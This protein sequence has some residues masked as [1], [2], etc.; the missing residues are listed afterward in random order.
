MDYKKEISDYLDA[1]LERKEFS[2]DRIK[3]QIKSSGFVCVFGIGAISYPIISSIR[4]FTDIKIDF[5][6]D[7][8]RTKWGKTYHDDLKCISPKE[9]EA[10]KDDIAI[11]ITTRHYK[12]IYKQL[13]EKGFKKIYAV[14][15]YRLL[16]DPY[17][18]N[19]ENIQTIKDNVL[20]VTDILEDER[21]KEIMFTVI[22]NWF[23]FDVD[24]EGYEGIFTNDQYYPADIIKLS[25]RESFVDVGAYNGDTV[26]DFLKETNNQFDS[27]FAFELDKKNFKEME[28]V[29]DK[30]AAPV[31]KKIK[32]YNFGLLDEE[33]EVYYETGGSGMQSTFINVINTA[34]DCGKTVR[35]TDILKNEKVT[36]IKMDIEGSEVK[37]LSGAEVIIKRQKPKLAICV[38]HKP[39]HLWEVPLY[40][41][42]IVPEYKMYLRHHT[43]LEYETVCYALI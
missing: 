43:P 40:V 20:K 13:S 24:T 3:A 2:I 19:K 11:L 39:E 23:D 22:K 42:T 29:V 34:S 25:A 4:N 8:D 32:L 38:Y 16:N 6:S 5:L 10:Y 7:N 28:S 1:V 26:I 15:E 12:N 37:A 41:K 18:K 9:L 31:K 17:F 14:T 33:K 36:F 35:L 30:L 27:I 21:S